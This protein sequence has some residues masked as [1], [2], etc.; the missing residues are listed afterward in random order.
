MGFNFVGAWMRDFTGFGLVLLCSED[1]MAADYIK[2]ASRKRW[3]RL[4]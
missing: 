2:I 4:L 1:R 3:Y